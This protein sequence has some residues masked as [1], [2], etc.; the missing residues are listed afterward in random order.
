MERCGFP[1]V[2]V[3]LPLFF[4]LIS[5]NLVF[6]LFKLR[7]QIFVLPQDWWEFVLW[8]G[9]WSLPFL[10]LAKHLAKKNSSIFQTATYWKFLTVGALLFKYLAAPF[11]YEPFR[12]YFV[13]V[14]YIGAL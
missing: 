7:F 11:L 9:V 14:T 5:I 10:F 1:L 13:Y 2:A 3:A 8:F 4:A 6:C 12:S